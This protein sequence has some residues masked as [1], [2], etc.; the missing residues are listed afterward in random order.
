V[1]GR[2][3]AAWARGCVASVELDEA[4]V[5][6]AQGDFSTAA[7]RDDHA[8]HL[9]A[10]DG[11]HE[12]RSMVAV[13]V[14]VARDDVHRHLL[15]E[16]L[17]E[18]QRNVEARHPDVDEGQPVAVRVH[19]VRDALH[20]A[21]RFAHLLHRDGGHHHHEQ[22]RRFEVAALHVDGEV[23]LRRV[24]ARLD[25]AD[26]VVRSEEHVAGRILDGLRETFTKKIVDG[27]QRVHGHLHSHI[28]GTHGRV[29]LRRIRIP[30]NGRFV[31]R[32]AVVFVINWP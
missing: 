3:L 16:L 28:R 5:D 7:F 17:R 10:L 13:E 2:L 24:G 4:V 27:N 19:P 15:P 30:Q 29:D 31:N 9:A 20:D 8:S 26:T 32:K 6:A 22:R 21:R 12:G 14:A 23:V 18:R 11:V 1:G 25:A